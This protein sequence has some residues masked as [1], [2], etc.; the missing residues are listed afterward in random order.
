[1]DFVQKRPKNEQ[2]GTK[3]EW[4]LTKK[5]HRKWTGSGNQSKKKKKKSDSQVMLG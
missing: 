4:K 5:K 1:M 2:E 3:N